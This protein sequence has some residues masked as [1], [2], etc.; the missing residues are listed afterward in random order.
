MDPKTIKRI[1][2]AT[3]FSESSNEAVETAVAFAHERGATVEL[4][5]VA[6]EIAYIVPPPMDVMSVPF[7][8][9]KTLS[10]AATRMA[11]EERR[12]LAKGVACESNVLVGRADTEIVRHADETHSDLIVLGT[13]GRTGL[14][15]ALLGS[16][17]ERVVQ[18]AHCPVLTVP[19]RQERLV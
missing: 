1:M 2:V 19:Y 4:V 7:D 11:S 16:I 8:M 12:V 13:H 18:H 6:A 17:A 15:H 14:G 5:H 3:D 9:E 10:A